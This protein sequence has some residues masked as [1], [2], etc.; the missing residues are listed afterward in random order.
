MRFLSYSIHLFQNSDVVA[1][2]VINI[3]W[4]V[5]PF[6][7]FLDVK[8]DNKT[9]EHTQNQQTLNHDNKQR[10]LIQMSSF[11][12]WPT[13][14]YSFLG[15]FFDPKVILS[16]FWFDACLHVTWYKQFETHIA[17][18]AFWNEK[19]HKFDRYVFIKFIL[20]YR[21]TN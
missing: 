16:C 8:V 18:L 5:R 7:P 2:Q 17:I 10:Y 13:L 4:Q 3:S 14:R 9:R 1:Y 12:T 19:I 15:Y 20:D 21:D 11:E 6:N